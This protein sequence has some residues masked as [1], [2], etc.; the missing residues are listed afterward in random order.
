MPPPVT[1][2]VECTPVDE[3]LSIGFLAD[4]LFSPLTICFSICLMMSSLA[5]GATQCSS[6]LIHIVSRAAGVG[7]PTKQSSWCWRA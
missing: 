1:S 4:F 7:G 2:N 5:G 3:G 6:A